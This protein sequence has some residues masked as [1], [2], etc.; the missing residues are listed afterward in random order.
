M[1]KLIFRFN[2][3]CSAKL[4]KLRLVFVKYPEVEAV[5]L[6]GSAASNKQISNGI[7]TDIDLG[8]VASDNSIEKRKVNLHADM[9]RQGLDHVDLV[10]FDSADLIL[11]FEIIHQ[12]KLIY[13]K[14]EFK[15]GELFSNTIRKYLD[16]KPY[17]DRQR[18]NLKSRIING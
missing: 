15:H 6:F 8:I 11:Q 1:L 7:D 4:K 14:E 5:Y 2:M 18:K 3:L 13:S 12:N 16:F 10:F 9:I 17:L